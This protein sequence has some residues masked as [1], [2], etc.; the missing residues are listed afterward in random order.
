MYAIAEQL[1]LS[2]ITARE[3]LPVLVLQINTYE[4]RPVCTLK[5]QG[6][7]VGCEGLNPQ[8]ISLS[9]DTL[10]VVSGNS[11]Q[12]FET[13]QGR[14]VGEQY[15]HGLEINAICLS[16]VGDSC[17]MLSGKPKSVPL[18]LMKPDWSASQQVCH[19]GLALSMQ[20][21]SWQ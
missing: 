7:G 14:P 5:L 1:Q 19:A 10:A 8:L 13:A 2:P 18:A 11:V 21:T 20:V 17:C 3:T 6:Q 12:C 9:N 16:Q 4:G 15:N